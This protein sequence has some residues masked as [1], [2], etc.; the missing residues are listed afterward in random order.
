MSSKGKTHV[1]DTEL[2]MEEL[3]AFS[4]KHENLI[5]SVSD[6]VYTR[7][8]TSLMNACKDKRLLEAVGNNLMLSAGL[9]FQQL[10]GV[11]LLEDELKDARSVSDKLRRENDQVHIALGTENAKVASLAK[12]RSTALKEKKQALQEKAAVLEAKRKL[13]EEKSKSDE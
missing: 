5:L 11:Q 3:Q 8:L 1:Q 2:S 4:P 13:E 7:K 12:E 6:L 10:E 9:V